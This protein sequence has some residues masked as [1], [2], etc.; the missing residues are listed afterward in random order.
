MFLND[1]FKNVPWAVCLLVDLAGGVGSPADELRR[2]E[3]E[4]DLV[5][6]TQDGIGAVAHVAT[7]IDGVVTADGARKGVCGVGGTKKH[8]AALHH[9]LPFPH[10]ADNR[11]RREVLHKVIVEGLGGEID[12]VALGHLG[13]GLQH[14][15]GD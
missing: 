13:S 6:G 10:H 1:Y 5:L 8:T 2:L 12:V 9:V 11:A 7:D 3:P 14:L 15:E 4:S